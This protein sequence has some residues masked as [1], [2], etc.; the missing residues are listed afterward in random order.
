[1]QSQLRESASVIEMSR[2]ATKSTSAM[3]QTRAIRKPSSSLSERLVVGVG[4]TAMRNEQVDEERIS[5]ELAEQASV[6]TELCQEEV[7]VMAQVTNTEKIRRMPWLLA[8]SAT[9]AI[10]TAIIAFGAP[11]ILFLDEL[12]LPKTQIG[13]IQSLIPFCGILALFIAPVIAR[14]GVKR[15]FLIFWCARHIVYAGLLLCPLILATFG[16]HATFVYVAGIILVFALC[17]AIAETAWCP[18]FQEIIPDSLRGRF[19]AMMSVTANLVGLISLAAAGYVLGRSEGLGRFMLLIVVGVLFGLVSTWLIVFIPGGEP[20][21]HSGPRITHLGGIKQALADRGFVLYLSG[22]GLLLLWSG[23]LSFIPLYMKEQIGLS[24]AHVV[25]LGI[26]T[27]A[28]MI[29]SSYLWGW[30][31]DRYGSRPVLLSGLFIM[32]LLPV[33]WM[34]MPRHSPWSLVAAMAIALFHGV[35]SAG[36]SAGNQRLL[37][38]SV[39]PA[40]RK[41]QYMALYYAW[42]GMVGGIGPLL[43]GWGLDHFQGISGSIF[44]LPID[45]YTPLL[46]VS[47]LLVG[48]AISLLSRVRADT[49]VSAAEFARLFLRGSPLRAMDSLVR[50]HLARDE[51]ARVAVTEEMGLARS[52]LNVAELVEALHDPSFNVCYEA[53]VSA[54]RTRPDTRLTD[55][56]IEVLRGQEPELGIAASWALARLGDA[57]AVEALREALVSPYP[58]L[59]ASS[60]RAVATLGDR[61]SI[62]LLQ[63]RLRTEEHESLRVAYASALGALQANEATGDILSYLWEVDGEMLRREAALAVARIVGDE[64]AFIRL[65]RQF[66]ADPGTAAAAALLTVHRNLTKRGEIRAK[67]LSTMKKCTQAFG[68]EDLDRGCELLV[69]SLYQLPTKDFG[70]TASVVL[71]ECRRI[72]SQSGQQRTEYILLALHTLSTVTDK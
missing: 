56:L 36:W 20:A 53:I 17:R 44:I 6:A 24:Q 52:P 42:M 71:G 21:D 14:F 37:Y 16:V 18:W 12:G 33:A 47:V 70:V 10:F 22:L 41:T 30:T 58:L 43:A 55:A 8:Q 49:E 57:R 59:R 62:P 5:P 11:F 9:S 23:C 27:M 19:G 63:E 48:G 50:Y 34:M 35:G 66:R 46:V 40:P 2:L 31:A 60:A 4:L 69:Q 64:R 13:F 7:K 15:T 61:E 54:A 68:L 28:G 51:S 32:L 29:I 72:L 65:W 39:I 38:V 1:M 3:I 45:S 67:A 26:G 25:M